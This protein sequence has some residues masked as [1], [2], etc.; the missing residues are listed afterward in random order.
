[1]RVEDSSMTAEILFVL[2]DYLTSSQS[3]MMFFRYAADRSADDQIL[4]MTMSQKTGVDRDASDCCSTEELTLRSISWVDFA[5][6]QARPCRR[7]F[8][9]YL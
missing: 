7:G 8:L 6:S 3:N 5:D 1:M 9:S 2:R 4:S